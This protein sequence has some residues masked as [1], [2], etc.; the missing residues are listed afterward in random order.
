MHLSLPYVTDPNIV[1]FVVTVTDEHFQEIMGIR[2]ADAYEYLS[3]NDVKW[4]VREI[5]DMDG[6]N[7]NLVYIDTYNVPLSFVYFILKVFCETVE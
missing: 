1:R 6:D 7:E 3:L 5:D 4:D 2:E